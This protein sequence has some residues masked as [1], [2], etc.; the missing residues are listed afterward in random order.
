MI[1]NAVLFCLLAG[2]VLA[3]DAVA[4]D[5]FVETVV[6]T[7]V[8]QQLARACPTL[9]LNPQ[10][11]AKDSDGLMNRLAEDGIMLASEMPWADD[12]S[13]RIEAEVEAFVAEYGLDAPT[14]EKVCGA[15]RA[16]IAA[17]SAIGRYLLEVPS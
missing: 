6:A 11:V 1:R 9:S 7:G 16:E 17:E 8:A 13:A 10:T 3:E 2:P 5:Y 14:E 12:A 15:G 4:P